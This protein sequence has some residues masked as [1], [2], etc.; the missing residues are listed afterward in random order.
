MMPV[1][2]LGSMLE[3]SVAKA[4]KE[5]VL[6]APFIKAQ[7]LRRVLA[8]VPETVTSILCVT[9]W[10]PEDIADGVCDLDIFDVLNATGRGK[11]HIHPN[12]HAKYFR[13]DD[14]C[15]VGSANL[16]RKAL[17]WSTP[18]NIEI[19][20]PVPAKTLETWEERLIRTSIEVTPEIRDQI[21]AEAE[22]LKSSRKARRVPE[23]ETE[24]D[25]STWFPSCPRP[26]LLYAVY[27]GAD[28][29]LMLGTTHDY[30]ERDLV[31][32]APPTGLSEDLF[33]Q[34][35]RTTLLNVPLIEKISQFCEVGLTDAKAVEMIIE[36]NESD[37]EIRPQD[38]WS[39]FKGWMI[40]FFP[41][42]YRV[43]TSEEVLV[44]SRRINR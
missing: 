42:I 30:A 37:A 41:D 27:S 2:V 39:T 16:T 4:S 40:H 28:N 26:D 1:A 6:V 23:V 9:R 24:S 31:V 25:V 33:N 5:V 43:E 20:I 7:A 10:L 12:L 29:S 19:M 8:Q 13:C 3:E 44:K 38:R 14:E 36:L 15:L 35:I 18:A 17:G 34:H 32:L 21:G 11:L 22:R